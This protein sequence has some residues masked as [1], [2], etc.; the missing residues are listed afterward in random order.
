[1]NKNTLRNMIEHFK[2][3]AD[4]VS[5]DKDNFTMPR[6]FQYICEELFS[7]NVWIENHCENHEEIKNPYELIY[8][9]LLRKEIEELKI[10]VKELDEIICKVISSKKV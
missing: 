2:N 3:E 6:S 8:I 10:Y 4:S 9:N 5:M 1:M 7:T